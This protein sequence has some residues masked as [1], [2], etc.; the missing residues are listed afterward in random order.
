M[1]SFIFSKNKNFETYMQTYLNLRFKGHS[2]NTT[3][4]IIHKQFIQDKD[5][6]IQLFFSLLCKI[7]LT[8]ND[9]TNPNNFPYVY[10][11]LLDKYKLNFTKKNS[12]F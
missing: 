12:W 6:L 5:I 7:S 4:I 8:S 11:C 3:K 1:Q 9:Q 10:N 2:R